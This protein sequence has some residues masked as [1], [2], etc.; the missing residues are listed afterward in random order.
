MLAQAICITSTAA[1][2]YF[3][4]SSAIITFNHVF[5]SNSGS[6]SVGHRNHKEKLHSILTEMYSQ[7]ATFQKFCRYCIVVLVFFPQ[8]LALAIKNPKNT[9]H[10]DALG[11]CQSMN[12]IYMMP[13]LS[14]KSLLSAH[15]LDFTLNVNVSSELNAQS[16]KVKFSAFF[17]V[18]FTFSSH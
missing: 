13:K 3:V 14:F 10:P 1:S 9:N 18:G 6:V 16:Y 17:G 4:S 11:C 8:P 2:F 7:S 15:F 12:H 5:Q